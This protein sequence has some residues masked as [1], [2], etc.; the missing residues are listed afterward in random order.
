MFPEFMIF[1]RIF[2]KNRWESASRSGASRGPSPFQLFGE[3]SGVDQKKSFLYENF[4]LSLH[5]ACFRYFDV[6][7][8]EI[9][10]CIHNNPTNPDRCL[11]GLP[12][13]T[14]LAYTF[15]HRSADLLFFSVAF[16]VNI[17]VFANVPVFHGFSAINF[18][19]VFPFS[20]PEELLRRAKA[21]NSNKLE[22][23]LRP[24]QFL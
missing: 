16:F 6:C 20:P 13:C 15:Y 14:V 5:F 2:N 7:V 22:K 10:L 9:S 4:S 18:L 21:T 12:R 11:P 19:T 8:G 24:E 23:T 3:S 17:P 1:G